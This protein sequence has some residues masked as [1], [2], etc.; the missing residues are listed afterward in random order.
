MSFAHNFIVY[1]T[2]SQ[3]KLSP[4]LYHGAKVEWSFLKSNSVTYWISISFS[5]NINKYA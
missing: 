1:I 3:K 2:T 4:Y 5:P